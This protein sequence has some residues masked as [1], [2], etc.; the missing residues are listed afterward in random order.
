MRLVAQ[1][2]GGEGNKI[3]KGFRLR[4]FSV[5]VGQVVQ[6][7]GRW[8]RARRGKASWGYNVCAERGRRLAALLSVSVGVAAA[9]RGGAELGNETLGAGRS[10]FCRFWLFFFVASWGAWLEQWRLSVL[11]WVVGNLVVLI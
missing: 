6:T 7:R 11:F 1:N 10:F 9:A 5:V 8:P 4:N 2:A 3:K